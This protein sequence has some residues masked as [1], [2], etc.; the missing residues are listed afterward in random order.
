[1]SVAGNT[2]EPCTHTR[3]YLQ[4]TLTQTATDLECFQS[5][6]CCRPK[7]PPSH[8]ILTTV[9]TGLAQG[10][11]TPTS[12]QGSTTTISTTGLANLD[13]MRLSEGFEAC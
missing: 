10:H 5:V 11:L 3:I 9:V 6:K 13:M 4:V 7:L 2:G 8:L 12:Q 1:M